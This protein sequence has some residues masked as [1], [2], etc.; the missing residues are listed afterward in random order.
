MPIRSDDQIRLKAAQGKVFNDRR[1]FRVVLAGRRGGKTVLALVE[2]LRAAVENPGGTY[3]YV[4]PT[5]RQAK[6]ISW[7]LSK[8]IFPRKWIKKRHEGDLKITLV[9]GSTIEL[10][11]AENYDN[12]RG[13]SLSGAVLDEFCFMHEQVWRAIIRPALSDQGGWALFISTPST[14]GL[15]GWAYELYLLLTDPD[16]ADPTLA[17]L[18]PTEWGLHQYTTLQGGNVS[19]KEV[20]QARA[21]L[22]EA[23]FRREYEAQ[24]IPESGLVAACFSNDNLSAEVT[25][26]P[27]LPLLVGVDFN[28]DPLTAVFGVIR[29][30]KLLIHD[31]VAIENATTWDLAEEIIGRY[32]QSRTIYVCPDP[33]GARK[34]TSG[35]GLSDHAILKRYGFRVVAPKAPWNVKD[36][37]MAVNAA[38]RTADGVVH[39]LIHPGCRELIKSFRS[40]GYKPGTT[41]PNKDLGVDH[42]FDAFGYLCLG[43][44]NRAKPKSGVVTDFRLY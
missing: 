34:Q 18:D 11:G 35:V 6:D 13:R 12:L 44:F 41:I 21:E 10:K 27:D 26:I 43:K 28:V 24:F 2:L 25:D 15:Q 3:F 31:E 37:I 32:G 36:K 39:T 8:D 9:N 30:D 33:T 38:L 22:D 4:A 1:R 14:N 42:A 5:F 19:A 20:E 29:H 16:S 7:D 23:S 17:R 40:L